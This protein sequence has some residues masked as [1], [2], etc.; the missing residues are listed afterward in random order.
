MLLYLCRWEQHP[1][2]GTPP[3]AVFGYGCCTIKHNI[4][5]YGGFCGHGECLHNCLNVIN[6]ND[7]LWKEL[8]P[9]SDQIQQMKK[10]GGSLI[11]FDSLLLAVGGVGY[12][13]PKN[14]TPS[15][16]Y[17]KDS[18]NFVYTNEHLVYDTEGG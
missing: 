18:N 2:I 3:L 4:Y 10:T 6:V 9:T 13:P 16:T 15:A 8:S 17:E 12:S 11:S 5:Y 7:F 1:T 14:P